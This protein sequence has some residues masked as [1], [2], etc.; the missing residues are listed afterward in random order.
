MTWRADLH[1][2]TT[3]SDGQ[4]TP[5]HVVAMARTLGL[6][7]IAITDHETTLGVAPA[8]RAA[9]G[10]DLLVVSGVEISV[11]SPQGEIHILGYLIEPNG[12]DLEKR[13]GEL[14]EGRLARAHR[15]LNK[16]ANLGMPLSWE[17]L[18]Q[19]A[20]GDSVG[21]PHVA[22]AMLEKGYVTSIDEAFNLYIGTG[23]PAYVER[24]RVAPSEAIALI[25]NAGGVPVL[26]HPLQVN[27]A[28]PALVQAGLQG[29]ETCY[30]GYS[31]DEVQFLDALAHQYGLLTTGGSDFHGP[32]TAGGA[33][34]EATAPFETIAALYA[35]R[36]PRS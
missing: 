11:E 24:L 36:L 20:A 19:L 5:E 1:I 7:A 21:R 23:A 29:L 28:V 9:A 17:R 34:G 10:T 2:H 6:R 18:K 35:R 22:R 30:T 31:P 33:L 32:N 15:M 13:L 3:A 14:R 8:Q 16:L 12:H 25:R 26:A 27:S 4:F